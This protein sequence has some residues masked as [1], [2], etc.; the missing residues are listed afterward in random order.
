MVCKCC[1]DVEGKGVLGGIAIEKVIFEL[2]LR[3]SPSTWALGWRRASQA[4]RIL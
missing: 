1:G 2:S 3:G 4:E